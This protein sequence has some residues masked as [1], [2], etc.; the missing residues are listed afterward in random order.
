[1]RNLSLHQGQI[2][3]SMS[4]LVQRLVCASQCVQPQ[5]HEGEFAGRIVGEL[6]IRLIRD[7]QATFCCPFLSHRNCPAS[8][9]SANDNEEHFA[10]GMLIVHHVSMAN[11]RC[12]WD[13][14]NYLLLSLPVH[15]IYYY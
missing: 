6:R 15:I 1:M 4:M 8:T 11:K 7:E 13:I 12:L 9:A 10:Q 5:P 14:I 3:Y 2:T